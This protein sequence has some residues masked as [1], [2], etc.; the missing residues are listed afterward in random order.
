G[1][2]GSVTSDCGKLLKAHMSNLG[3]RLPETL[4]FGM[5]RPAIP[6]YGALQDREP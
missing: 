5:P 4:R 1:L 2:P 6:K 3:L